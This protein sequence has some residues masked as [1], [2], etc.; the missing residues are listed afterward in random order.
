MGR[1]ILAGGSLL[2]IFSGTFGGGTG[3]GWRALDSTGFA[4]AGSSLVTE[5]EVEEGWL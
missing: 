2:A 5:A 3:F 1:F 4:G